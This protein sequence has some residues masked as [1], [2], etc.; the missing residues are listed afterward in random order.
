M[1]IIVE[2]VVRVVFFINKLKVRIKDSISTHDL[3]LY[4]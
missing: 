2:V 4:F 1:K 3:N